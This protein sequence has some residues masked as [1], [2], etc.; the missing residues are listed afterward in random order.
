MVY[1]IIQDLGL[2]FSLTARFYAVYQ[3]AQNGSNGIKFSKP[4]GTA[5]PSI[6]F[7]VNTDVRKQVD[8]MTACSDNVHYATRFQL[9]E[10]IFSSVML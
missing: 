8:L 5:A 3:K 4:N 2:G 7:T 1:S 10:L 9:Q 6:E